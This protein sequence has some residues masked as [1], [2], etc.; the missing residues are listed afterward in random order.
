MTEFLAQRFSLT[1]L[2]GAGSFGEVWAAHDRQRNEQVA[3]K[4][5]KRASPAAIVRFK[6]EFRALR[7][8]SHPN[9]IGLREL[10]GEGDGW[11][12]TMELVDG[13]DLAAWLG[14]SRLAAPT[15]ASGDEGLAGCDVPPLRLD[16]ARLGAALA[17]LADGLDAV[18]VAGH[19]HC[20][21]KPNN[22]L[23]DRD[24]RVRLCDFGMVADIGDVAAAGTP[25]FMAPEQVRGAA[26][27]PAADWYAVGVMLF[28]LC[29]GRLPFVGSAADVRAAKLAAAAPALPAAIAA[30]MPRSLVALID[31]LLARAPEARPGSR[32]VREVAHALA[33]LG[34][35]P[36]VVARGGDTPLFGRAR[37]LAAL[38]EAF[39]E[40]R[41][42]HAVVATVTGPSGI[43]KTAT[44]RQFV[45][46]LPPDA[47]VLAARSYE[48]EAMPFRAIDAIIDA[49]ALRLASAPAI[50]TGLADRGALGRLFP[51]L[52]PVLGDDA[53]LAPA[54]LRR[55]GFAAFRALC[56]AIAATR[57]LVLWLDDLQWSDRDSAALLA[58]L[59]RGPDAPAVLTIAA[60][61]AAD[62][63][64]SPVLR[65][66]G[67][68]AGPR[69]VAVALDGLDRAA[70]AALATAVA[71]DAQAIDPDAIAAESAGSPFLV[72][73]LA[74][75][76]RRGAGLTVDELVGARVAALPPA[77]QALLRAL[78]L[79]GR[80]IGERS[81]IAAAGSEAA[82]VRAL[83]TLGLVR[84]TAQR[85]GDDE[86]DTY[87]DRIR[88][89]VI[90]ACPP[91][92]RRPVHR[93]LALALD[94]RGGDRELVALQWRAAGDRAA[95]SI[96]AALAATDAVAARAFDRAAALWALAADTADDRAVADAHALAAAEALIGAG[97]PRAAA[98][99][100]VELAARSPV[101]RATELRRRAAEVLLRS[102]HLALGLSELDDVLARLGLSLP[103]TPRRALASLAW[104][105]ARLAVR[106]TRF[107]ERAAADV[108]PVALTRVD[109][110]W[111]VAVSL[112]MTDHIRGADFQARY[113]LAAL[114][115]GEPT[116]VARALALEAAYMATTGP[117]GRARCQ[118]L[119][120]RAADLAERTDD[121]LARAMTTFATGVAAHQG[122]DWQIARDR[123]AAAIARFE[124][125][126]GTSFE[127]SIAEF[128][129]LESL[130]YLGDMDQLLAALPVAL[131]DAERRGD[132]YAANY[133]RGGPPNIAWL[134][135]G[136]PARAL[137]EA[138]DAAAMWPAG[139]GFHVQHYCAMLVETQAHLYQ[140]DGAAAWAR[141]ARDW[142]GLERSML[143]RAQNVLIEGLYLR[144]RAA[145]AAGGD[146]MI[147]RAARD[148][149]RI[150]AE[151]MPWG[152][153][154]AALIEA[155]VATARGAR[156]DW[157][158][159]AASL[160]ALDMRLHAG[161]ARHRAGV[162]VEPRLAAMAPVFAPL[163]PLAARG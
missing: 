5:L 114:A 111:S 158:A 100:F 146:A 54:E 32:E 108:D 19:L 87:H 145:L 15:M 14:A 80:P 70:A 48:H 71:P 123:C 153:G 122:G 18:H 45:Q 113:T 72:R 130:I 13:V 85:R 97:Q 117:R 35:A 33:D 10:F 63:A 3:L 23:V 132:V 46:R 38:A 157:L 110:C 51:A 137:T 39:A 118:R 98:A 76:A 29:A 139:G 135:R 40:T 59:W 99:A 73:E 25:W 128:F 64:H 49:L 69:V 102:G 53:A 136:E 30:A 56:A 140:G 115:V 31:Q 11:F 17:Q 151:H 88:E 83:R 154:L 156:A 2:L 16:A 106:G 129:W 104:H 75:A 112:G 61:R 92:A 6:R 90:A 60:C 121:A 24:G 77:A 150:R 66:L 119:A 4:L 8:L 89:A 134:W 55:R 152:D 1:R 96:S 116:R 125:V 47:W 27:G 52:R 160:D 107:R 91:E 84:T 65:A 37:E 103:P 74:L 86:L 124:A 28:E 67:E 44:V 141:I 58:A 95:A 21:L 131:A 143:L 93:A 155:G 94:A 109:A 79:A 126:T 105:R 162:A 22:V 81:A 82:D 101:A 142:R 12:Y 7:D 57:P 133:L 147:A 20:D 34:A 148:A 159:I 138:R 50:A 62:A 68:L 127:T 149:A 26:I 144:A 43:G 120:D 78:A 163:A 9:L 36:A 41:A 42:G 161:A